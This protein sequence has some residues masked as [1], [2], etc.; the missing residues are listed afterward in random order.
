[1][2]LDGVTDSGAITSDGVTASGRAGHRVIANV[3][4]LS[5]ERLE[6]QAAVGG[7]R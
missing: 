7:R 3:L 5:R 1:M 6:R 4:R 2:T